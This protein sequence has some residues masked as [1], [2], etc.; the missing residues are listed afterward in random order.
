MK[1]KVNL[2]LPVEFKSYLLQIKSEY[3]NK[4][5]KDIVMELEHPFVKPK[6]KNV[7]DKI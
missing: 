7:W 5:Y 4:K 2:V 3:P 6:K 1:N